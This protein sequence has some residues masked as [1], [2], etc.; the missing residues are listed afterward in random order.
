MGPKM[1]KR[2]TNIRK[3]REQ[4]GEITLQAHIYLSSQKKINYLRSA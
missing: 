4:A 1:I 2:Y 3:S